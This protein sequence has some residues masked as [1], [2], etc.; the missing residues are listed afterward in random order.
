MWK[1]LCK[2][3]LTSTVKSTYP[4]DKSFSQNQT[5]SDSETGVDLQV[6][7]FIRFLNGDEGDVGEAVLFDDIVDFGGPSLWPDGSFDLFG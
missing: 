2:S 4:E 7:W 3:T 1:T 6:F 5:Y